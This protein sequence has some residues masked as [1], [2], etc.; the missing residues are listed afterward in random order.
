[1]TMQPGHLQAPTPLCCQ[2]YKVG[3]KSWWEEGQDPGGLQDLMA[4]R[5]EMRASQPIP[6]RGQLGAAVVCTSPGR[7]ESGFWGGLVI[8]V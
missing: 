2:I 3:S 7:A 5:W 6:S 4:L 1:M 8:Q